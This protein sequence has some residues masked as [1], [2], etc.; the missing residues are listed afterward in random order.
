[1]EWRPRCLRGRVASRSVSSRV[2]RVPRVTRG[3]ACHAPHASATRDTRIPSWCTCRERESE[4]ARPWSERGSRD[5][6]SRASIARPEMAR[7]TASEPR[8]RRP[9]P[10]GRGWVWVWVMGEGAR[11]WARRDALAPRESRH[12]CCSRSRC[13]VPRGEKRE[14]GREAESG[15]ETGSA[16]Q[17]LAKG[18]AQGVRVTRAVV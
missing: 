14:G 18:P 10:R 16:F 8:G 17:G 11:S 9:E 1:M 7:D 3:V 12:A 5:G 6:W 4:R 2:A 15:G 13:L